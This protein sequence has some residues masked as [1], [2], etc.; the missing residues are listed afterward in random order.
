MN[1]C[2]LALIACQVLTVVYMVRLA[3]VI[4]TVPAVAPDASART[5]NDPDYSV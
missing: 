3:S 5:G 4:S 1:V 2:R